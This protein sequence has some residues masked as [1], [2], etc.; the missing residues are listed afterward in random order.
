MSAPFIC[1]QCGGKLEVEKAHGNTSEG[2]NIVLSG[3]ALKCPHCGT[4]YLPE[5]NSENGTENATISIK[6]S[7]VEG[8][9]IIGNGNIIIN[10]KEE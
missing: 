10:R 5:E 7:L 9:I 4:E 3:Q 8:N 1:T 2:K 6:G